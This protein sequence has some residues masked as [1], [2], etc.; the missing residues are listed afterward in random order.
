MNVVK[1]RDEVPLIQELSDDTLRLIYATTVM[2]AI[3]KLVSAHDILSLSLDIAKKFRSEFLYD[4]VIDKSAM[5]D[6]VTIRRELV[7][8]HW[9]DFKP[10]KLLDQY[11]AKM[12]TL[13]LLVNK[14]PI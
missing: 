3:K 10:Q 12:G 1:L 11:A 4:P 6:L 14:Q 9:I 8:Y 2:Q 7:V 5:Q 13:F